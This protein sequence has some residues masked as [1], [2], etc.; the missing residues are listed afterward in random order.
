MSSK[1]LAT[2]HGDLELPA[3]LPDATRGVVR[4]LD[5]NDLEAIGIDACVVNTLHL[6]HEP[7]ISVVERAGGMHRFMRWDRPLASDSGGFQAF[8]LARSGGGSVHVT[9]KELAYRRFKGDERH[10]LSP[11][12]CIKLQ[13]DL[14]ADLMF[15]LDECTHPD[16]AEDAQ[17][18]SVDHTIEWAKRCR[19]EFL[20][21]AQ[22]LEPSRRPK[23]FAVVQ[24]GTSVELRKRCAGELVAIG[25]EGYA[26]GGWP[27]DDEGRLLDAVGL[28]AESLPRDAPKHALGIGKLESIVRTHALGYDLFDCVLPTRDARMGR[29]Y[30]LDPDLD[31][32]I[33]TASKPSSY[34]YVKDDKHFD[35]DAPVDAS[36]DCSTCA[37]YSRGY[38]RHLFAIG[39][40]TAGRL[41]TIH[42]LRAYVRLMHALRA[43]TS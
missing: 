36:C 28:T 40:T 33:R 10:T 9:N 11:E 3:F 6:R 1:S 26:Y 43:A 27:V 8:S 15:C 22:R 20:T 29:L 5:S 14:G 25:F 42:N 24:G 32:T 35:S 2:E 37:R 31:A 21:R 18:A 38:L 17:R 19:A 13:F 16:Q 41:A 7:G 34:V 39:E 4:C 30:V 23:L 12:Q